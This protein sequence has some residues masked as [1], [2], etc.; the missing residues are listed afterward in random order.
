[1]NTIKVLTRKLLIIGGILAIILIAYITAASASQDNPA[2]NN[3][4]Y[5]LAQSKSINTYGSLLFDSGWDYVG[6]SPD[7]YPI[8]YNHNIGG[9]ANDYVVNL[10]CLDFSALGTYDC[11]NHDFNINAHWYGLT[12][13][14]INVWVSGSGLPVYIRLRIYT[15]PTVYNSGWYAIG[16]H[17][18]PIPISFDLGY[19]KYNLDNLVIKLDCSDDTS[20][21]TY[22]CTNQNFDIDAHWYDMG[23]TDI[24]VYVRGG[25]RPDAVR[26]RFFSEVP[27]YNGDWHTIGVRPDSLPIPFQHNLGGNSNEYIIELDCKDDTELGFYDCTNQLFNQGTHW[28]G[29]NNTNIDLWISGGSMPDDVR[30]RI[31]RQNL[32]IPK[33]IYLSLVIKNYSCGGP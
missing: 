25:S 12:N 19:I 9:N 18:D 5:R 30:V 2:D 11:T 32:T 21:G 13:S 24:K 16:I 6:V 26:V 29:M 15:K 4:P 27:A 28:Y 31:W 1:M 14:K 3:N 8:V 17:P 22:D 7:P 33:K 23:G 10:E 20:L